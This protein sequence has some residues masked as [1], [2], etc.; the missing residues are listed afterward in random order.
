MTLTKNFNIIFFNKIESII[1]VNLELDNIN[2]QNFLL[3]SE[4]EICI[5]RWIKEK[6]SV[7]LFTHYWEN[8]IKNI[9]IN[10]ELD[11]ISP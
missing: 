10:K 11:N 6:V 3:I 9:F 8:Q 5:A 4:G 1:L 2:L 7:F